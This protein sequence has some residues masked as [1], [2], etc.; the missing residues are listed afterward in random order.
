MPMV[1]QLLREL[2]EPLKLWQFAQ[3]TRWYFMQWWCDHWRIAAVTA[4]WM[5]VQL[6]T[7]QLATLQLVTL[8]L[9]TLQLATISSRHLTTRHHYI[10]PPLHLA[11]LTSRHHYISPPLHFTITIHCKKYQLF[12]FNIT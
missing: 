7:L 10:S 9:A 12:F 11:T 4:R 1:E 3:K 2:P 8:Q 5:P 6:A